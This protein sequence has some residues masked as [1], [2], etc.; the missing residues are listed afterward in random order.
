MLFSGKMEDMIGNC[1][2]EQYAAVLALLS[3][4]EANAKTMCEIFS[5]SHTAA[6]VDALAGTNEGLNTLYLVLCAALVFV[7]H[8]GKWMFLWLF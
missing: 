3:G 2:Q 6:S 1:D 5:T 4:N 8:A 7:M